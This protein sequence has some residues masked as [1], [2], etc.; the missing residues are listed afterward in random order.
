MKKPSFNRTIMLASAGTLAFA[1]SIAVAAGKTDPPPA[2][3]QPLRLHQITVPFDAIIP[4]F[5]DDEVAPQGSIFQDE[6]SDFE[7]VGVLFG[8]TNNGSIRLDFLISNIRNDMPV[9][10]YLACS[11]ALAA[12]PENELPL[13][14][15]SRHGSNGPDTKPNQE[16]T[17]PDKPREP[18]PPPQSRRKPAHSPGQSPASPPRPGTGSSPPPVNAGQICL[19]MENYEVI[20]GVRVEPV[21]QF[22]EGHSKIGRTLRNPHSVTISVELSD[23]LDIELGEEIYFQAVA[24]PAGTTDF[25][26]A[27]TSECDRFLIDK[28]VEGEEGSTGSKNDPDMEMYEEPNGEEPSGEE[29]QSGSKF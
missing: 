2:E 8:G 11:T 20:A 3:P 7:N 25:G 10:V 13:G 21:Q 19:S 12:F 18:P 9:D 14:L 16:I 15:E 1:P 22:L 28:F 26:Q 4:P 23:L 29:P 17:K 27:Q 24:F 6:L 5:N